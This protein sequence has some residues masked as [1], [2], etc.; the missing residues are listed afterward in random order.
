MDLQDLRDANH[1]MNK[2]DELEGLLR[3]ISDRGV[4]FVEHDRVRSLGRMQLDPSDNDKLRMTMKAA[5]IKW[6]R[7][8]IDEHRRE[9]NALGIETDKAAE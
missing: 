2:I 8:K 4:D 7:D 5:A 6:F 9:I 3:E 1:H